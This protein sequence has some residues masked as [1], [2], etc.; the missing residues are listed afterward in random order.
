[1]ATILRKFSVAAIA[2]VQTHP[3][4]M[5]QAMIAKRKLIHGIP[6]LSYT[7]VCVLN[8]YIIGHSPLGLFRTK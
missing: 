1:M 2:V 4:A 8:V 6:F 3:Q 7:Y 5:T